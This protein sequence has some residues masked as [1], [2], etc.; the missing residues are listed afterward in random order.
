MGINVG[1]G[2]DENLNIAKDRF[3]SKL[4]LF[5]F[6]DFVDLRNLVYGLIGS[7]HKSILRRFIQLY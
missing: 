6:L 5:G 3:P 7:N 4:N 2:L 1:S